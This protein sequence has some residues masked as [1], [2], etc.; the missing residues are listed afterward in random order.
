MAMLG[1]RSTIAY[2]ELTL[3]AD[4]YVQF[5]TNRTAQICGYYLLRR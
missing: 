4:S 2:G 1:R 5:V 3:T